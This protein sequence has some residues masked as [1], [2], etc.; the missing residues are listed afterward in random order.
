[1]VRQINER[2]VR[3]PALCTERG[4]PLIT[5]RRCAER[6]HVKRGARDLWLTFHAQEPSGSPADGFGLLATL[7]E[8]R[9]PPGGVS[10]PLPAE[11]AELITYVYRGALAQ[12]DSTGRSGVLHAGEFQRMSTG[13]GIRRKESNASRLEGAR[14]FRIALHPAMAESE[15][16][17]EQ[18]RFAAAQRRN[19]LC[20]VASADG[21]R[22]SLRLGQDAVILSSIL[23]PGHHV[24]HELLPGRSAW[25]HVVCGEANLQDI[26]LTRGDGA[27]V[28]SEPSVSFTAQESTEVLLVDLGPAPPSS[29][30]R[31]SDKA[32]LRGG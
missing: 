2:H 14:A 25:L 18:Q 28:A 20:V 22:R 4:E 16:A 9:L 15:Q 26:I 27:G 17:C 21:R 29:A 31:V 19:L 23:D 32:V 5:L 24:I 13:R 10:A 7:D 8:L 3:S 12:Q 11:E 6:H 1:M 30:S